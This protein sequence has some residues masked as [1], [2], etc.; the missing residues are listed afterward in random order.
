MKR[1]QSI[2]AWS[3]VLQVGFKTMDR[4]KCLNGQWNKLIFG[5]GPWSSGKLTPP[6]HTPRTAHIH[7]EE[8]HIYN[9]LI[10]IDHIDRL[11]QTNND[12][13]FTR[14]R[15]KPWSMRGVD[16]WL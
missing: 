7:S 14:S 15:L 3:R 6:P 12:K 2:K 5:S 4:S 8:I 9:F 1:I 10:K 13:R 16:R 11:D